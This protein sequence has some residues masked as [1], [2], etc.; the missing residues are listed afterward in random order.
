[1][2]W[3][4]SG[5]NRHPREPVYYLKMADLYLSRGLKEKAFE[6]LQTAWNLNPNSPKVIQQIGEDFDRVGR[7]DLAQQC[8]AKEKTVDGGKDLRAVSTTNIPP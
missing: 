4:R 2:E 5:I 8:Y 7:A 1:M 3:Y 6:K